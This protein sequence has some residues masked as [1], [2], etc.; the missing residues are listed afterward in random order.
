M[1]FEIPFDEVTFSE[2]N[3]LNF[4]IHWDK[5][6]KINRNRIYWAIPLLIF[7][8][9]IVYKKDNLGFLFIGI[10]V[11]YFIKTLEYYNFY[12]KNKTNHLELIAS[13]IEK[14]K[15]S[16]VNSTL[17]FTDEYF[18]FSD[19]NYDTKIFWTTFKS[20][21]LIDENLFLDVNSNYYSSYIIGKSEVGTEK[22]EEIIKLITTKIQ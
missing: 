14:R 3:K 4:K 1:K 7:G 12:R 8:C 10:A 2:Q 6:L 5:N 19:H 15:A 18:R 13:K 11:H 22:F 20:Y 16:E 9:L 17:E 21:R